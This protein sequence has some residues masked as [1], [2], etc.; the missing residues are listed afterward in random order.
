MSP[1]RE[2]SNSLIL[3]RAPSP[4]LSP[5]AQSPPTILHH[6]PLSY[7]APS[8]LPSSQFIHTLHVNSRRAGISGW[9]A[10]GWIPGEGGIR[11]IPGSPRVQCQQSSVFVWVFPLHPF[12]STTKVFA[13]SKV[14]TGLFQNLKRVLH[15]IVK[16]ASSAVG[17]LGG[18]EILSSKN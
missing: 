18:G 12:L 1:R 17:F 5:S 14:A 4:S 6:F 13:F 3:P 16:R 9:P 15:I 11:A 7:L 2:G 10:Y 8:N